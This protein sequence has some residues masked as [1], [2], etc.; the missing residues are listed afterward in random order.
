M[1]A[2]KIG[3]GDTITTKLSCASRKKESTETA[4]IFPV[5]LILQKA[6]PEPK[7]C[8]QPTITQVS[9]LHYE[10]RRR[11]TVQSFPITTRTS[12]SSEAAL[13][14]HTQSIPYHAHPQQRL[15]G[16]HSTHERLVCCAPSIYLFS[17][18]QAPLSN[19]YA[20]Y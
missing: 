5:A 20:W 8:C 2:K 15:D 6:S 12:R 7:N 18:L 19:A 16:S 17:Q 13:S 9:P 11:S 4:V 14:W 3:T 1:R 10:R